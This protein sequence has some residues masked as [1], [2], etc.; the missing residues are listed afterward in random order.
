MSGLKDKFKLEAG[1]PIEVEAGK[2]IV[3]V[4]NV[5]IDE[6]LVCANG[7]LL[8]SFH[9]EFDVKMFLSYLQQTN[10]KHYPKKI[11]DII[12]DNYAFGQ[13]GIILGKDGNI[14]T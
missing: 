12:R 9:N 10:F 13:K 4:G 2:N 5:P 7:F 3:F 1:F 14:I 11:M 6:W 8:A